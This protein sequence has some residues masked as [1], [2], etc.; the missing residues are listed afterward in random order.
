M[1]ACCLFEVISIDQ[2]VPSYHN[3]LIQRIIKNVKLGQQMTLFLQFH[4]PPSQLDHEKLIRWHEKGQNDVHEE[5]ETSQIR[6]EINRLIHPESMSI[7]LL[8]A[9][10]LELNSHLPLN[11]RSHLLF[12]W[13]ILK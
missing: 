13:L 10:L 11:K 6:T 4:H 9:A 7:D 5:E 1:T 2:S 3:H 12:L 8:Q